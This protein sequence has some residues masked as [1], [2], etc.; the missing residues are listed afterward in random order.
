MSNKNTPEQDAIQYLEEWSES[1][2]TAFSLADAA[3]E[4]GLDEETTSVFICNLEDVDT[5]KEMLQGDYSTFDVW[6]SAIFNDAYGCLLSDI[7]GDD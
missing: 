5:M 2:N 6:D 4:V 7:F 1:I 3:K